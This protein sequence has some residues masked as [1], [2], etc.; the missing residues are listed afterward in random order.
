[1]AMNANL[2]E[3]YAAAQAANRFVEPGTDAP[4]Q[5]AKA[6]EDI[7]RDPAVAHVVHSEFSKP[8]AGKNRAGDKEEGE[9]KLRVSRTALAEM[10]LLT[11]VWRVPSSRWIRVVH[12]GYGNAAWQDALRASKLCFVAASAHPEGVYVHIPPDTGRE[13]IFHMLKKLNFGVREQTHFAEMKRAN[14]SRLQF[15]DELI[16]TPTDEPQE[17]KSDGEGQESST[18][19]SGKDTPPRDESGEQPVPLR[20]GASAMLASAAFPKEPTLGPEHVKELNGYLD[21]LLGNQDKE[22]RQERKEKGQGKHQRDGQTSALNSNFKI[23]K[24]PQGKHE[25]NG[26]HGIPLDCF[27]DAPHRRPWEHEAYPPPPP[28][29]DMPMDYHAQA[30]Q[31]NFNPMGQYYHPGYAP[32][33]VPGGYPAFIPGPP[34]YGQDG[35]PVYMCVGIMPGTGAQR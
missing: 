32:M 9:Q 24:R 2:K 8:K 23:K 27:M 31:Q 35:F 25:K 34:V 19:A 21:G 6:K 28:P 33:Q 3:D 15:K 20:S 4:V 30:M 29:P 12:S 16:I 18:T 11:Q 17:P 1:M 13:A 26:K 14:K 7:I 5:P 10:R 22:H